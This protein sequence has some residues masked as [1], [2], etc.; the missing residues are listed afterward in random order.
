MIRF[1]FLLCGLMFLAACSDES[2][3]PTSSSSNGSLEAQI[4]HYLA[5]HPGRELMAGAAIAVQRGDEQLFAKGYGQ[6]DMTWDINMPADASFW[7]GSVTK[8]F[9]AVAIL[10][11]VEQ[12]KIALEDDFTEYI[13]YDT[14]GKPVT[15]YQ[16]LNHTSGLKSY[17]EYEAFWPMS[18]L[19]GPRDTLLR[20]ME[21]QGFDFEPGTAMIYNNSAYVM[22]GMIIEKVTGMTY[23]DYLDEHVFAKAGLLNT[24]YCDNQQIHEREATGYTVGPDTQLVR[25]A[26]IDH[27]WPYAAGSLCSTPEDLI[28][29]NQALHRDQKLLQPS[30]YE[31]LVT[32]A[33]LKDGTSLRYT[34]GLIRDT[35]GGHLMIHH[36]GGINGFVSDVRYFPDEDLTV[37][38]LINTTGPVRATAL[39]DTIS[40]M[41]LD[42]KS[43][44]PAPFQGNMN[45]ITGTYQGPGRGRNLTVEAKVEDDFLLVRALPT[46]NWDTLSYRGNQTWEID[47]QWFSFSSN[48]A[49]MNVHTTSGYFVLERR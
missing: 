25:A 12:G 11:L 44:T 42:M 47:N 1:L 32:P 20:M 31:W 7:I 41:I 40:R 15:I 49:R 28:T 10:Q 26:Y 19:A 13:D 17:T 29:W 22:L 39:T 21:P 46:T 33:Q 30:T 23:A 35:I 5:D 6:A 45:Q 9:T 3:G 37:V 48:P 43:T 2:S 14:E 18:R 27:V 24:Y 4:D 38:A 34:M 8:Q 36:G 16:L